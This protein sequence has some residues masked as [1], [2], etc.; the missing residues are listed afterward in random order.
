MQLIRPAR[1]PIHPGGPRTA[2][3]TFPALALPHKDTSGKAQDRTQC[4]MERGKWEWDIKAT[5]T[6]PRK[7]ANL[8]LG[9]GVL[10]EVG[11]IEYSKTQI[12]S[13]GR[14]SR[15]LVETSPNQGR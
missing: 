14:M 1:A 3:L 12:S 15:I 9:N 2:S 8:E 10:G 4:Y 13:E 5:D 11:K 7:T 6:V